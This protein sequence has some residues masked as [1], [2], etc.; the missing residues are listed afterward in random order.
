MQVRERQAAA[1]LGLPSRIRD[2]DCDIEPLSPMDLESEV[3][4][5]DPS[6]GSCQPEHVTYAIKM[7]EIAK[8]RENTTVSPF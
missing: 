6:F 3:S 2:D 5:V 1:A 8:L 7:V 4:P